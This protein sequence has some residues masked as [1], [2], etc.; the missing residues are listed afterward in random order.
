VNK[1]VIV[2]GGSG[3]IGVH[4][5]RCLSELQCQVVVLA[6]GTNCVF[7]GSK[8]VAFYP[9]NV[10]VEEEV[11]RSIAE[12]TKTHHGIDGVIYSAGRS[13]DVT[14]PLVR[15]PSLEFKKTFDI[16]VV[17]FLHVFQAV[18]PHMNPGGHIVILGSAITRF[19]SDGL[20]PK[21]AI[22]EL[23]KWARREAHNERVLLSVVAPGA[24]D[25]ISHRIGALGKI[26]KNLLP[27]T[28]VTEV[29]LGMLQKGIEGDIQVVG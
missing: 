1:V 27:V 20:P 24:V 28:A 5:V 4:L 10:T 21:A 22:A 18:L 9:T 7:P 29:I 6:R 13:P 23:A 26:P 15:Y 17:G 2:V 25:T 14:V 12:I 8:D 19:P 3:G 16:Y 11:R